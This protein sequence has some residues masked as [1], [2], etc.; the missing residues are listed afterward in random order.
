[1]LSQASE[2]RAKVDFFRDLFRARADVYAVH[3]NNARTG[4]AGWMPAVEGGWRKGMDRSSVRH[5]ALTPEVIAEHLAG[6]RHIGLYPLLPGD[7]TNWLAADFDGRQAMLDSLAYLK[8]ARAQGV[9]AALEVSQSGLG[10][11]VWVFFVDAIGAQEARRLGMGLVRE[12]MAIRGRM[13]LAAYDRLFPSQDVLPVGGFGNLIAAPLQGTCRRRGTTVFLDLA[14]MEPHDD[15]WA[16]LST[17][18]RMSPREVSR[19]VGRLGDPSVGT[20]AARIS[21]A[22]ATRIHPRRQRRHH[23]G[24]RRG[25]DPAARVHAHACSQPAKSRVRRTAAP[26]TLN[27]EHPAVHPVLR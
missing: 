21:E 12:A 22:R 2:A 16:Y 1:M 15:Q 26:A 24:P 19:A 6:Q 5:L 11:H 25:S 20:R 4:Q 10:A 17:L 27:V 23:R 9:P 14:T 8:A 7:R 13:S 3:W 18:D